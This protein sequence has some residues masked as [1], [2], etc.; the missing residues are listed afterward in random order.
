MVG[1]AG[2]EEV[3]GLRNLKH[4]RSTSK[5]AHGLSDAFIQGKQALSFADPRIWLQLLAAFFHVYWALEEELR[6]H[7]E[8]PIFVQL[9]P[10][11]AK[12][13]RSAA[14]LDDIMFHS[15]GAD[16]A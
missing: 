13:G 14:F 1:T 8:H 6:R 10:Q 4:M 3:G 11:L 12:L 16:K 2:G 5:R 7:Q 15:I 9:A